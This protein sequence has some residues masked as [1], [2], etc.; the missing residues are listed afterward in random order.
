MAD[1][2]IEKSRSALRGALLALVAEKMFTELSI[3]EIVARAGIGYATFFRHYPDKDALLVDIADGLIDELLVQMLPALLE[4][5]TLAASVA[6]CRFVDGRRAICR[7]LLAGGATAS[8]RR[9]VLARAGGVAL[10]AVSG[11]P[12]DLVIGHAVGATLGLLGWWLD[13]EEAFDAEAMGAII[14]RLVMAPIR[15]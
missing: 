11:L 6:L 13:H 12:P 10:P 14:D 3:G 5:K 7:A 1:P 8:V 9:H 4:E 15:R 2:R